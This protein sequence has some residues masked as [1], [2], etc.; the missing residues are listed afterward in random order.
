M[1]T[2][3]QKAILLALNDVQ[4]NSGF[5]AAEKRN[6][7][8]I[9]STYDNLKLYGYT[10][11]W[12]MENDVGSTMIDELQAF[13]VFMKARYSSTLTTELLAGNRVRE[14]YVRTTTT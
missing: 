6:D 3:D 1:L 5:T 2:D 11:L 4:N 8:S 14:M 9:S 7:I 13:S 10:P 12:I